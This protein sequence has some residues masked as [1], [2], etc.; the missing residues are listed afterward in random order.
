MKV[1]ILPILDDNYS[2]I[3]E[4]ENGDVAVIDPGEAA[5]I[6]DWLEQNNKR[7][8]HIINTHHHG[9]HIAGNKELQEKY[10]AILAAPK[11][12]MHRIPGVDIE[13]EEGTTFTFG[14]EEAQIIDTPGHTVGHIALYFPNSKAL[15][16]GDTL[17]SMGCGRLFEGTA[18]QMWNSFEKIMDLPDDTLIYPGHEYTQS[19]GEFCLRI[20][21][22]NTELKQRMNEVIDLRAQ[23]LPTI[24]TTLGL[25]KQTNAFLRAGSAKEFAKIRALKDQR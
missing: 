8:T 5:P 20:D 2:Y 6:I 1:H 22:D 14:G 16:C 18:E 21:P 15:F 9:D 7:L 4:N 25:E 13:L 11:A 23:N 19:N 3:L 17:F 12:D 24:P 10:S